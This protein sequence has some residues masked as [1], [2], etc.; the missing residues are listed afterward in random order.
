MHFLLAVLSLTLQQA[1]QV[2][3]A[4]TPI[5]QEAQSNVAYYGAQVRYQRAGL[6]PL[7]TAS[8]SYTRDYQQRTAS[9]TTLSATHGP[10]YYTNNGA[11]VSLSQLLFDGG[12]IR[13][14][15]A[16]AQATESAYSATYRRS[17]QQVAF[18]VAQAYYN[19]LAAQQ[20]LAAYQDVLRQDILLENVVREQ[21]HAGTAAGASLATQQATTAM[22]RTQVAQEQGTLAQYRSTLAT[23]MGLRADTTITP[24]DDT[25]GLH[26]TLPPIAVPVFDDAVRT[27][28]SSRPDLQS[29]IDTLQASQASL[30]AAQLARVPSVSMS[31]TKGLTSTAI[32]GGN[33]GNTASANATLSIPIY[34]DA[35]SADIQAAHATVQYG[36]ATVQAERLTVQQDVQS[37]LSGLTSAQ[38]VL[39]SARAQ[40]T[41]ANVSLQMTQGQYRV[42]VTSIEALVQAETTYSSAAATY[43]S[44]IYSLRQAQSTLQYALGT[45][46]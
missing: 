46:V 20:T 35:L 2:A 14:R 27:A 4:N 43:I 12:Q 42:G 36:A 17:A 18:N 38:S 45:N 23:T 37:A 9:I 7:V 13:A 26:A 21:I 39:T 28:Y 22:A 10:L 24:Q 5:L 25:G 40:F 44:A 41:S 34:D 32:N 3:L 31:L 29:T 19:V 1:V 16:S 11:A 15:V 30:K 6:L 33:F 8:G